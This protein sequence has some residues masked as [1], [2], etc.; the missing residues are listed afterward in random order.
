MFR[1]AHNNLNVLDLERSMKF[2]KE[3]LGLTEVR[4]I[5]GEGFII[6]YLGDEEGS[7]H[8][9]TA[10]RFFCYGVSAECRQLALVLLGKRILGR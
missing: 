1:F 8:N 10:R 6:V 5:N 7:D 2:Y 3:A 9:D 4:R